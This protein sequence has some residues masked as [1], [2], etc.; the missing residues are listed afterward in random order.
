MI[1]AILLVAKMNQYMLFD[2][3]HCRF[4]RGG[5]YAVA[6]ALLDGGKVVLGVL[7]C[8]NLPLTSISG[9]ADHQHSPNDEVGCLFFAEVGGGTYMQPL[10]GSST[11]KVVTCN[12]LFLSIRACFFKLYILMG[13][14]CK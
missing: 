11:L 1:S 7:A 2:I 12:D 3:L 10:D 9:G 6:L 14:R 13:F 8:P 5:Q 4:V